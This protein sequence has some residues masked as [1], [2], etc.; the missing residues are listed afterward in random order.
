MI[1]QRG[2]V[3]LLTVAV[4]VGA[5]LLVG[6]LRRDAVET[7]LTLT[8]SQ[9]PT[10]RVAGFTYD[11]YYGT[12]AAEAVARSLQALLESPAVAREI[13]VTAG[14]TPPDSFL[15][16]RRAFATRLPGPQVLDVRMTTGTAEEG[17][18]LAAALQAVLGKTVTQWNARAV[19]EWSLFLDAQAPVMLPQR[20]PY[21]LAVSLA[22]VAG[23]LLGSVLVAARANV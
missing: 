21:G 15:R 10:K 7:A 19:S 11:G 1:R 17:T 8:V 14:L 20:F 5:T 13:F 23:L 22:A 12:Q 16:L 2:W 4:A 6:T 3:L 9:V 18:A